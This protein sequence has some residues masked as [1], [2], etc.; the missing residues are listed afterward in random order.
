[1]S[2]RTRRSLAFL[3]FF[4]VLAAPAAWAQKTGA[5]SPLVAGLPLPGGIAPLLRVAEVPGSAEAATAM[6]AFVHAVYAGKARPATRIARYLEDVSR[7]ESAVQDLPNHEI[8]LSST[9]SPTSAVRDVVAACGYAFVGGRLVPAPAPDAAAR[10]QALILAGFR[11]DEWA[12]KLGAG[13]RVR[14]EIST[15]VVPLPLSA[16]TWS[17]AV[18]HQKVPTTRLAAAI[19]GNQ[20]AALVYHGLM[21]LD[22]ETLAYLQDHPALL[23]TIVEKSPGVFA[24]WGRS[25]HVRSRKVQV[26]GGDAAV[27]LW[28]AVVGES[29]A[30]ADAFIRALLGHDGGRTAYFFDAI[31]HLDP[32]H[33]AFALGAPSGTDRV[34]RFKALYSGIVRT[35]TIDSS[36]VWPSVRHPVSLAMILSQVM[37]SPDGQM[38]PPAATS[39]WEAVLDGSAQGCTR[40]RGGTTAVDAAWLID[41]FERK[42]LEKRG[43]WL[44]AVTFAQRVFRGVDAGQAPAACEAVASFPRAQGLLL[45]M[46]RMGLHDPADYVSAVRFASGLSAGVDRSAAV[47]R[48]AQA[49]GALVILEQ[50]TTARTIDRDAARR[51]VRSLVNVQATTPGAIG[52][53]MLGTMLPA[54]CPST[55]AADACSVGAVAGPGLP[56]DGAQSVL[57]EEQRYRIDLAAATA[58]RLERVRQAQ[59]A[60]RLEDGLT[61]LKAAVALSNAGVSAAD[62]DTQL[63]IL[64]ALAPSLRSDVPELFGHPAPAVHP[65]LDAA[66]AKLPTARTA[67]D[68]AAL[69]AGLLT[70]ADVLLAD[71]LVSFAYA[72]AIGEP[73]DAVLMAGDPSRQH[74][75]DST[76]GPAIDAWHLPEEVETPDRTRLMEGSLFSLQG[77]F[78]RSWLHRLSIQDPGMRP[79]PDPQDVLV[80]GHTVASF[81]PYALTNATRDAIVAAVRRGRTAFNDLAGRG[82]ALW[83]EAPRVGVSEWRCRAARWTREQG[84]GEA[85]PTDF[86]ALSEL[87][88]LGHPEADVAALDAWGVSA[89]PVDG[90]LSLR[91]P[92][93]HA[94]EDFQGPRGVGV[95]AAQTADVHIHV[96]EMLADLELPASLAPGLAAY[97]VW[98]V[99]TTAEMAHPDDF[100]ALVRATRLLPP[101]RTFDYVST[102]TATGP[103]VPTTA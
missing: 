8:A 59:H 3:S 56:A 23:S 11:V 21:A 5:A 32:G 28:Q 18:L 48:T 99:L 13:E 46:E 43:E 91:M 41:S 57:W 80:F 39:F 89:Y 9:G 97:I 64:K 53:W 44:G 68:R 50:A 37:V 51:L 17:N 75:F 22:D 49:Q 63:A 86:V 54:L 76:L 87:M 79:R 71:A 93:G 60:T 35:K 70:A 2:R 92:R 24:E 84:R 19:F 34:G 52:Q 38:V 78:A 29:P 74:R 16:D 15:E 33:Q 55:H 62:A 40:A 20:S 4:V 90:S 12:R 58:V 14:I 30:D 85:H 95:L 102:L 65:S 101:D 88:W 67:N 6:V 36:S 26:P 96:A 1:M 69:T 100:L 31:A 61:V 77:V 66:L 42:F 103:L 45:T 81:N 98:D 72:T 94:S 47:I 25:I 83:E 10:R 7:L 73:D 27:A 82:D